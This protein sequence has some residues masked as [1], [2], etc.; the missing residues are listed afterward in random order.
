MMYRMMIAAALLVTTVVGSPVMAAQVLQPLFPGSSQ[1]NNVIAH[2][3]RNA[4]RGT[5]S[6]PRGTMAPSR[7]TTARSQAPANPGWNGAW[8]SGRNINGSWYPN[9]SAMVRSYCRTNK[10]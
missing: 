5:T 9:N 8:G 10:C 4:P 6:G 1:Y 3:N 2:T 7:N